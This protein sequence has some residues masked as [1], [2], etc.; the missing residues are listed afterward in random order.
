MRVLYDGQIFSVQKIGGVSRYFYE[1]FKGN[2]ESRISVI[3]SENFYLKAGKETKDFRGKYRIISEINKVKNIWDISRGD[4]EIFHPTYYDS[5]FLKYNK[6]PFVLT[7]YDMIHEIYRGKYFPMEDK[8]LEHK[9]ELCSRAAGIIAVSEKTKKDLIQI[10]GIEPEKIKVIYLGSDLEK[11]IKE[12]DLPEK[13]ILFVGSRARYKNFENFFQGVSQLLKKDETLSLVC[14][15]SKF[16][17]EEKN[18]IEESGVQGRVF[19][20]LAQD[21]ELYTIYKNALCFVFPSFY[22][23][24]GIPILEAFQSECPLVISRASCFPEIV[25][26]AGEYF[27]P[28]DI[29]SIKNAVETVIY[30]KERREEL[31]ELGKKQ[32]EKFSWEKTARETEAFYREIL[33]RYKDQKRN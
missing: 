18:R 21:D 28:E 33:S 27:D 1:L 16:T 30:S 9:R 10:L 3:Y 20:I 19:Q 12:I 25:E 32:L 31:I 22:E 13:Y 5:Y 15:G 6:K 8:T 7:V 17:Q 23:G 29:E 4:F 11:K 2:P 26:E 14:V 24:F